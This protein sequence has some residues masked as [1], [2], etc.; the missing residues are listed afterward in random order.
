MNWLVL[1]ILLTAVFNA[2]QAL[3]NDAKWLRWGVVVYWMA[4]SVFW[5]MRAAETV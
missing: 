5:L 1:M 3:V 4:V 2:T